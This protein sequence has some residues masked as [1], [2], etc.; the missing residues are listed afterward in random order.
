M[1]TPAKGN[2][3]ETEPSEPPTS[4]PIDIPNPIA[5]S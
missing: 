3:Q 1:D 4:G 2:R 5:A